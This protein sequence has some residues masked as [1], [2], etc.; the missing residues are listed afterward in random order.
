MKQRKKFPP[1]T[2]SNYR[3]GLEEQIVQQLKRLKISFGY[4]S[5]KIPYIRPEK[6]HKYTP[7][8]ILH[9]RGA[10]SKE[11]CTYLIDFFELASYN[12]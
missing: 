10:V 3:S 9:K 12:F 5:E 11:D 8:F 6:L 1:K 4:E 7:D 2:T